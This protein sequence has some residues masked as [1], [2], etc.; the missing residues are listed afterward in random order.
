MQIKKIFSGN[1][2][3]LKPLI[4]AKIDLVLNIPRVIKNRNSFSKSE[5]EVFKNLK[6]TKIFWEPN[7]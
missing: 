4:L 1:F 5:F 6:E 3:I 2:K 7:K